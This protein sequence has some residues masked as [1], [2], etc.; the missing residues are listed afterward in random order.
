MHAIS[1]TRP[2]HI[3]SDFDHSVYSLILTQDVAKLMFLLWN[4][5]VKIFHKMN[6]HAGR[7]YCM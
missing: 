1:C 6:I 5:E 7:Y 3:Y 4:G 2:S